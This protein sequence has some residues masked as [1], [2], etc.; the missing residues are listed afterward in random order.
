MA[1][2]QPEPLNDSLETS[3]EKTLRT[4]QLKRVEKTSQEPTRRRK[5]PFA[6]V[7]RSHSPR[8]G[9]MPP[10]TPDIEQV[11]PSRARYP[12]ELPKRPVEVEVA[13]PDADEGTGDNFCLSVALSVLTIVVLCAVF[14]YSWASG[15]A[16]K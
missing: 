4:E 10:R 11:T 2:R 8:P 13:K 7:A 15:N 14:C 9:Y 16:V 5:S 3:V 1:S 6:T 12:E